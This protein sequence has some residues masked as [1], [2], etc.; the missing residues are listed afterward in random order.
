MAS[1]PPHALT[2]NVR[3]AIFRAGVSR[4]SVAEALGISRRTLYNRLGNGRFT[5]VD[6][7]VIAEATGTTF[8]EVLPDE[9][10]AAS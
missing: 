7:Q 2:E 10:K 3:L 6:L 8:H 1:T 5:L 4:S 9:A